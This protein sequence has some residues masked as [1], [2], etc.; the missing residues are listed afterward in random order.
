MILYKLHLLNNYKLLLPLLV[1]LHTHPPLQLHPGVGA[2]VP[3]EV[4]LVT[5]FQLL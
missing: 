2:V 4:P 1:I 3:P 5:T